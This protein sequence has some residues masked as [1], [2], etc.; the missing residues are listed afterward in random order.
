M[1]MW[2]KSEYAEKLP[3]FSKI[4]ESEAEAVIPAPTLTPGGRKR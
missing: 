3:H 1:G 2:G 4:A